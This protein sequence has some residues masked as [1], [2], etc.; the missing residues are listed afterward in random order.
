MNLTA[1]VF[2]VDS[3]NKTSGT[4]DSELVDF[5]NQPLNITPAADF[6]EAQDHII[7]LQHS[8]R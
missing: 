1:N 3:I 6:L 7:I 8:I 5:F 2:D 4:V